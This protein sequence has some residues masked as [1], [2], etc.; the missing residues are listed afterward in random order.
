MTTL[1]DLK[2]N[3]S[4]KI[5]PALRTAL[6][7][8]AKAIDAGGG[9][10]GNVTGPA[11][12]TDGHLAV[13]DGPTGKAIKD[14]GV[15]PGG[16]DLS[17][18]VSITQSDLTTLHSSPVE[19]IAQP[20]AGKVIFIIDAMIQYKAT[21]APFYPFGGGAT[22]W[23]L[24]YL[25][26]IPTPIFAGP[27]N[28]QATAGNY[29]SLGGD[30]NLSPGTSD[31]LVLTMDTDLGIWGPITSIAVSSGHAG[32]GYAPGDLFGITNDSFNSTNDAIGIILTVGGSG[33][34]TSVAITGAGTSR[35]TSY[36]TDTQ[37]GTTIVSG[38]GDGNL[39]VDT[40]ISSPATGPA[41]VDIVYRLIDLI[42]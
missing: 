37:V 14:G 5:D 17:A 28:P 33:D 39:L 11:S 32:A 23:K 7:L 31:A 9:G 26:A 30:S 13:F 40:T 20:I 36:H 41:Q 34:A 29:G 16:G 8:L 42:Q 12:A 4:A 24:S 22:N 6:Q 27:F 19:I 3:I 10:S 25:S 15:V 1:A 2:K 21:S 38:G 35:G 18:T